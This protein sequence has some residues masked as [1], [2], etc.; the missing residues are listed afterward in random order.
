MLENSTI[1]RNGRTYL[2]Y[3]ELKQ[4]S[5]GAEELKVLG[6]LLHLNQGLYTTVEDTLNLIDNIENCIKVKA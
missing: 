3:S 5:Y 4:L 6:Q 2:A 1:S